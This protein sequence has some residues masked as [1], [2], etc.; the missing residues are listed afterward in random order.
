M[1]LTLTDLLPVRRDRRKHTHGGIVRKLR[2][3]IQE[4][5]DWQAGADDYFERLTQDREQVYGAWQFAEQCRQEAETVAACLQ[6]ERDELLEESAE[7]RVEAQTLRARLAPYLA[8]EAN[9]T[10]VTVPPM[11]RDTS[12]TED[13][14]TG[15]IDVRGLRERFATGPVVSLHHSPQ[16]ASPTH[17]PSWAETTP[18][19]VVDDTQPTH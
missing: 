8:A 2:A 4:L 1:S 15:P 16:A 9:A 3:E 10:A 17:V 7:W 14:A 6:S 11:V 18:L 13:Q 5:L 19:P 12:A